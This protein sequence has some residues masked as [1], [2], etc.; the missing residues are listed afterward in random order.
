MKT[1]QRIVAVAAYIV[2]IVC[3]VAGDYN[4][5]SHMVIIGLLLDISAKLP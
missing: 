2:G 1:I 4:K 3:L 5:A